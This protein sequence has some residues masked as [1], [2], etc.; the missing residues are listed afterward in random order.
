VVLE[1]SILIR[2]PADE[3]W[4]YLGDVKNVSRWDRG[5]ASTEITSSTSSGVGLEFDTLARSPRTAKQKDWGK[6]SYRVTEIDRV[7]GCTIQ[8]TSR[9]GNARFFRNAE[10]RFRVEPD[11]LGSR[12]FC[13][14]DF[15]FRF[16][17][18][19][20]IPVFYFMKSA[21]QRDLE[22][23]RQQLESGAPA[24]A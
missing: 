21:I 22:S 24:A 8:L 12:V 20:L 13:A 17:W 15:R 3:V 23:L 1:T 18:Q 10:W 2:R 9:T 19:I 4:T 16:P 6:M 5:V 14:A 7:R 11:A